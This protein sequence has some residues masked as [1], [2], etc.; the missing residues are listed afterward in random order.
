M[1]YLNRGKLCI[2]VKEKQIISEN[3]TKKQ[4][5]LCL[6]LNNIIVYLENPKDYFQNYIHKG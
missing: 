6:Y 2:P 1:E 4:I 5:K 3:F